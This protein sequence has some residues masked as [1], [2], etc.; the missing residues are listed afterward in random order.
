MDQCKHCLCRGKLERCLETECNQHE[1]W[2]VKEIKRRYDNE[3][4]LQEMLLDAIEKIADGGE[5]SDFEMSFPL[6]RKV[7]EVCE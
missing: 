3:I 1:S 4:I 6:I 5:V 2:M 7:S